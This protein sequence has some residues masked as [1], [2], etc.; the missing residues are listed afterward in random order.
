MSEVLSRREFLGTTA[1]GAGAM[2][3]A[4]HAAGRVA[5]AAGSDGW[6]ELPA[7]R[8]HVA[9]VG[10]RG[11]AWPLPQFDVKAEAA[12]YEHRL[13]EAERRFPEFKLVGRDVVQSPADAARVAAAIKD[14]DG[15]LLFHLSLGTLPELQQIVDAG[16][17][18]VIYS[19][20]FSGHEWMFVVQWQ[21]AGK[22]VALIPTS[23]PGEIVQ[24]A[25]LAAVPGRMARSRLVVVG[26]PDGTAAA[27]SA[28]LVKQKLGVDVALV[29]VDRVIEAHRAVDPKAAEAEAEQVWI[30][31]AKRVL[32]PTR[33]EIIKSARMFFAMKAIM[34]AERAQAITVRCLGGIPIDVL[35]YPC[36]GFSRL[37]DMGYVGAC[38]AD[39][40]SSLTMLMFTYAF[41]VPGFITDPLFDLARNAVIHAHCTG[42]TR[43]DGPRGARAPFT[44]RTHRDDDK[45]AALAVEMRVGQRIT[46]AKL[47]NLD[48]MILSTGRITEIPDFEDRGCR[49]QI[50]TEVE[51]ARGML[52]NWGAGLVDGWMPQLHRVVFY[53]DR[54]AGVHHLSKLMGFRVIEG[55]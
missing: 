24:A 17:P 45:G 34:A 12:R 39:M 1:M 19:P 33:E 28:S 43:M 20:P 23:D 49:T 26:K 6:P 37:L 46:C 50:T 13:A 22:R 9:F 18:T 40:D 36:L 25:A 51:N 11:A 47:C 48:T 10:K 38:E 35:G 55:M 15:V 14:A 54:T 30:R 16:R 44:I 31:A 27:Q 21:K 53:G 4:W 2:L 52:D 41:G 32:E 3:L 8:V 42:P 5:M 29:G 7:G